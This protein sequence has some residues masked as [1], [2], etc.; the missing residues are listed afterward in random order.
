MSDPGNVRRIWPL[1]WVVDLEQSLSFWIDRLGFTLVGA[2]G[3]AG[4]RD[5]CR[6]ERGGASVMLQQSACGPGPGELRDGGDATA[7]EAEVESLTLYFVCDDVDALRADLIARG[8]DLPDPWVAPYGMKQLRIPDPDG[9]EIW[10]ESPTHPP[11][12]EAPE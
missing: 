1:L 6:V 3:E 12:Q 8:L 7:E 5:W 10:F 2:N 9:Y 4:V 11:V